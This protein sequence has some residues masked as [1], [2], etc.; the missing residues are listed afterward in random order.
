VM[1]KGGY[2]DISGDGDDR[3]RTGSI[4]YRP[5]LHTHTVR[6]DEGGCWTLLITG[7]K[8]RDW[9]FWING[10]WLRMRRYFR[11]YGHHPCA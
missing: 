10:Q 8:S 7:R 9:G 4:R 5:A 6:V 11:A 2:T 1:L 3:L